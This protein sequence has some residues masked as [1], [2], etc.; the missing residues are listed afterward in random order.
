MA[1]SHNLIIMKFQW[2]KFF[3]KA[4]L[5]SYEVFGG[6]W[7]TLGGASDDV[8]SERV[9]PTDV[10]K[11]WTAASILLKAD[12]VAASNFELYQL[13]DSG[14]EILIREHDLLTLLND[15]NPYFTRYW[16]FQRLS[17]HLDLYGNEYWWIV[18]GKDGKPFELFPLDPTLVMPVSDPKTY[19]SGYK[20]QQKDGGMVVFPAKDIVHFKDFNPFDD[21]L[22]MSTIDIAGDIILTD[23]YLN[24]WSK[25]YYK[26]S[27]MPDVVLEVPTELNEDQIARIRQDWI[28]QFSGVNRIGNVAV[29]H[30]GSKVTGLQ[31]SLGDMQL[32]QQ[33]NNYRDNIL[34]MFRTPKSMLGLMEDVNLASARTTESTYQKRAVY[35]RNLNIC[36]T[37]NEFL[38]YQFESN[39]NENTKGTQRFVL[40]PKLEIVSD[41]ENTNRNN[42]MYA[43]GI[44]TKN[45]WRAS[46]GKPP[47]DGGDTFINDKP[48]ETDN[49]AE[50]DDAI[51]N[52]DTKS[53]RGLIEQSIKGMKLEKKDVIDDVIAAITE[54][55]PAAPEMSKRTQLMQ[56]LPRQKRMTMA[57]FEDIGTKLKAKQDESE[58]RNVGKLKSAVRGLLDDQVTR[59]LK[60]VEAPKKALG[61]LLDRKKE[62]KTTIDLL[63]PILA[64]IIKEE[65]NLA[66]AEVGKEDDN[67]SNNLPSVRKYLKENTKK[68]AGSMTDTTIEAI[69]SAVADGLDAEEGIAEIKDRVMMAGN[70]GEARAQT[71]ALTETH[72]ASAF[73]ELEAFKESGVVVSKVWKTAED[74]RTCEDCSMMDG[75]EVGL[76]EAFLT[77]SDLS[78]IGIDNYDGDV[79]VAMMHPNCRCTVI[80]VIK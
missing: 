75:V 11:G 39:Q 49:S 3:Q 77:T 15:V 40:R 4:A 59:A 76:E 41:Q 24:L 20:Y 25:N 17:A 7:T 37:I 28:A 67:W 22:G 30:S 72:R 53:F 36:S 60:N 14:D 64:S 12:S 8:K 26:N 79:E 44:I 63:T 6:T 13:K 21:T 65:G 46:E 58:D 43:Q 45:E 47:I 23:K 80:P 54:K 42:M 74:E 57:D 61:P 9:R 50:E 31:K 29:M 70:L 66:L 62:I 55:E 68:L 56:R 52:E 10:Y 27:A 34:A 33:Q 73:A 69:R 48:I 38:I 18:R 32:V 1:I 19:V 16:L 71:I 78:E 51:L 35:P 2:P 5:K